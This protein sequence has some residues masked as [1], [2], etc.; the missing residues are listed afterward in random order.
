MELTFALTE[1]AK[2][3][4]FSSDHTQRFGSPRRRL[5]KACEVD[6][7]D[8]RTRPDL[9]LQSQL[10]GNQAKEAVVAKKREDKATAQHLLRP[11]GSKQHSQLKS[12]SLEKIRHAG[13]ATSTSARQKQQEQ[14]KK[15][16]EPE[17]LL[18]KSIP[19]YKTP[20]KSFF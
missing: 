18:F 4:V 5:V 3:P 19:A 16:T 20:L 15:R 10:G 1:V 11:M 14:L 7:V 12:K 13:V 2:E 17:R 8:R 9:E 6:V